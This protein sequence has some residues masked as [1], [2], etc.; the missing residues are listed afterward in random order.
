MSQTLLINAMASETR[1]ALL[2]GDRPVEF[3][4]ERTSD[5]SIVGNIYVGSVDRILPGMQAAF[6]DIGLDRC[7]FLYVD[8]AVIDT[9]PLERD[10]TTLGETHPKPQHRSGPKGDI[11]TVLHQGQH[12]VVQVLKDPV[13]TK[14][15]RLTR[16]ITLPGH[17]LVY[18]PF[19]PNI[20]ISN[21]ITDPAERKRLADLLTPLSADQG[22]WIARTLCE[23]VS[24][25]DLHEEA[26]KF[27]DLWKELSKVAASAKPKTRIHEELPLVA[28]AVRELLSPAVEQ[29]IV[30]DGAVFTE[31]CKHVSLIGPHLRG[32][33]RHYTDPEPLF[34]THGI[35]I[36][37][38]RALD[39]RVWLKSGGSLVIDHAEA[40][41]SIDVNTGRF[42]GKKSLEETVTQLNLEA[43][44]EI[45]YQLR[46]RNIGGIIVIDFV[47]MTQATNRERVLTALTRELSKDKVK[48]T[49]LRMS[50][51]GLVEMTRKRTRE[52]LTE[53]LTE[54][55]PHCRGRG[56]IKASETVSGDILRA[57]LRLGR[58]HAGGTLLLNLHPDM[59]KHVQEIHLQDIEIIEQRCS[60]QIVP[61]PRDGIPWEGFEILRVGG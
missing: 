37:L 5:R 61:V 8:D 9:P 33:I 52:S 39:R 30:D 50:E 15:A 51:I 22:G 29:I 4:I 41:T 25:E 44:R 23:G 11:A 35:E 19:E 7:G 31:L 57:L 49:V 18:L 6:I 10:P 17:R 48:S 27:R 45:A 36:D 3:L 12:V 32:H 14:G 24:N 20:G 21:R 38:N 43:V 56:R 16:K 53:L 28:R 2:E 34:E 47:D 59:A 60:I 55:C 58:Q 1:I 42:V 13:G 46:L 40:L 54:P 26:Q